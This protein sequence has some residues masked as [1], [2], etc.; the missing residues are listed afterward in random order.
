MVLLC[1]EYNVFLQQL[2]KCFKYWDTVYLRH[3]TICSKSSYYSPVKTF[4]ISKLVRTQSLELKHLNCCWVELRIWN[5]INIPHW[6]PPALKRTNKE[7]AFPKRGGARAVVWPAS[8]SWA[9]ELFHFVHRLHWNEQGK[10]WPLECFG[11][12][13]ASLMDTSTFSLDT[14]EDIS[15]FFL[16]TNVNSVPF[17]LFHQLSNCF[18]GLSTS[19]AFTFLITFHTFYWGEQRFVT[20]AELF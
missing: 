6:D 18:L 1:W 10:T 8:V 19:L 2:A 15:L 20:T 5:L 13:K 17:N 11:G 3:W 16:S 9:A 12:K 14:L 4:N 7:G